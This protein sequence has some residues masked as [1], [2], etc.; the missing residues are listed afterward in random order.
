MF[1]PVGDW[2]DDVSLGTDEAAAK[3]DRHVTQPQCVILTLIVRLL[4][5]IFTCQ[6]VYNLV[7]HYSLKL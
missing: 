7:N 4:E 5:L 2:S 3:E 1:P 6:T